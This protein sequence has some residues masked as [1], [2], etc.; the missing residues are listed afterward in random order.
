MSLEECNTPS[1]VLQ[2]DEALSCY[3]HNV[4]PRGRD[5]VIVATLL[6]R[7][8]HQNQHP[9]RTPGS[10]RLGSSTGSSTLRV[11]SCS[12]EHL[13]R[14][15]ALWGAK[16]P[17]QENSGQATKKRHVCQSAHPPSPFP[18]LLSPVSTSPL[19]DTPISSH[20]TS[21]YAPCMI[22]SSSRI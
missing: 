14:R 17:S 8:H 15:T 19:Y 4:P 16:F 13:S 11:S 6:F 5:A 22:R 12:S 2:Q 9:A 1:G 18:Y 3:R 10:P 21:L 7:I 20:N